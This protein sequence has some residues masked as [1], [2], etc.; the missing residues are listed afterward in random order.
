MSKSRKEKVSKVKY[1]SSNKKKRLSVIQSN[2][3][4]LKQY[5]TK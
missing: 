5:K 4:I 2:E 3:N 1:N